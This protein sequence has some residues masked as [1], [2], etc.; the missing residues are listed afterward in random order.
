MSFTIDLFHIF[1]IDKMAVLVVGSSLR[2]HLVVAKMNF[3]FVAFMT[4]DN[5]SNGLV[6]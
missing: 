6:S 5:E 4:L 2:I 3:L 1:V